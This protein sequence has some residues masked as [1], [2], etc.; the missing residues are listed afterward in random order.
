MLGDHLPF[1]ELFHERRIWVR[2]ALRRPLLLLLLLLLR[3]SLLLE[4]GDL[5]ASLLPSSGGLHARCRRVLEAPAVGVRLPR[6]GL[7]ARQLASASGLNARGRVL[8][9]LRLGKLAVLFLHLSIG[10]PFLVRLCPGED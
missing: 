8:L 3:R 2:R 5:A 4:V 7:S 10:I 9:L 6:V 1:G